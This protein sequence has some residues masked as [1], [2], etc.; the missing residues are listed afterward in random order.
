MTPRIVAAIANVHM[1]L[2]HE[3]LALIAKKFNINFKKLQDGELVLF[4]NRNKDKL[5]VMGPQQ[6]VLGYIRMPDGRKFPLDAIQW[7]PQTFSGSGEINLEAAI[8]KSI[9]E[10]MDK[11]SKGLRLYVS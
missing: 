8:E 11:K 5:K 2:G 3:G 9:Q 7:L 1:G 6:Q 4:I 10:S